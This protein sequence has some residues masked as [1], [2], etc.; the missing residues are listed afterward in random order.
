MYCM[1]WKSPLSTTCCRCAGA[2]ATRRGEAHG[3]HGQSQLRL[4]VLCCGDGWRWRWCGAAGTAAAASSVSVWQ[5]ACQ[6]VCRDTVP[7]GPDLQVCVPLVRRALVQH[8]GRPAQ[9]RLASSRQH[10]SLP[11]ATAAAAAAAAGER[12]L[13]VQAASCAGAAAACRYPCRR[14]RRA[15]GRHRHSGVPDR[16]SGR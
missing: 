5:S 6:A 3:R 12:R 4:A 1:Y 9:V 11:A 2:C 7:A 16:L 8:H 14:D 13:A 15:A 10:S